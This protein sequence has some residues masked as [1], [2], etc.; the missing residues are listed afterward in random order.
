M[1][2]CF[3]ETQQYICISGMSS[4]VGQMEEQQLEEK[5]EFVVQY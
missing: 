3:R 1:R 5:L 2:R 4:N